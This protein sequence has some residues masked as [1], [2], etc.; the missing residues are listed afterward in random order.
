MLRDPKEAA[1]LI[2]ERQP[3]R[4]MD[5]ILGRRG[6]A[7]GKFVGQLFRAGIL[8]AGPAK[9]VAGLFFVKKTNGDLRLIFDTRQPNC[10]YQEPCSVKLFSGDSLAALEM[11]PLDAAFVETGDVECCFY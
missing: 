9:A 10:F 8:E 7:Y 6:H 5:P 4:A 2:A 3:G 11:S 1:A